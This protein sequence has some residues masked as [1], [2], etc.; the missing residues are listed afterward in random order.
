VVPIHT[1]ESKCAGRPAAAVNA[2]EQMP[3]L[4]ETS[5]SRPR[6]NSWDCGG[7]A[8]EISSLCVQP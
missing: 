4:T 8:T 7:S 1:L 3:A 5:F 2:E 6:P